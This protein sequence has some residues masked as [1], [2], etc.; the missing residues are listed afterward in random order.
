MTTEEKLIEVI[1]QLE[2]VKGKCNML[3]FD[4]GISHAEKILRIWFF[5]ECLSIEKEP[6]V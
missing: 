2:G 5:E 6:T 3:S 1:T 4:D